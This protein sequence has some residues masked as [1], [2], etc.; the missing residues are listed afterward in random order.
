MVVFPKYIDSY[1]LCKC[2]YRLVSS[3]VFYRLDCLKVLLLSSL[4]LI[5][6]LSVNSNTSIYI[7]INLIQCIFLD[8][9][10]ISICM[11]CCN[12]NILDCHEEYYSLNVFTCYQCV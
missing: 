1:R 7:Q 12:S 3:S 9:N 11:S 2:K 4:K 5:S 6:I 10:A 8:T